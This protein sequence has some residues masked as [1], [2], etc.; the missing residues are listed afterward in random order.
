MTQPDYSAMIGEL[1]GE[2]T[3]MGRELSDIK[4]ERSENREANEREKERLWAAIETTQKSIQ[5]NQEDTITRLTSIEATLKAQKDLAAAQGAPSDG[6]GRDNR[7]W[8]YRGYGCPGAAGHYPLSCPSYFPV[9]YNVT[10]I[11]E[12]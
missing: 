8:D 1:R 9:A 10:I 12:C 11:L 3:G 6:Q 2:A 5:D 7:R 4:R